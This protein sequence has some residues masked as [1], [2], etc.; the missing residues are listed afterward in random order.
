M[1]RF[2]LFMGALLL[3]SSG[4]VVTR[5]SGAQEK[6]KDSAPA[7]SDSKIPQEELERKNPVPVTPERLAEAR[8]FYKYQCAM[9]HGDEGDGK[10]DLAD[11][12]KLKMSDWT[13]ATS[14]TGKTDGELFYILTNGKGQMT[15]QGDRIK[16]DMRW[17]LVNLIRSFSK[18][19]SKEKSAGNPKQ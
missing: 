5:Q 16:E 11:T 17:N 14:L 8:R 3:A 6:P 13:D 1:R 9:C 15:A 2:L 7:K 19:D 4:V 12:M 10:G 18:K